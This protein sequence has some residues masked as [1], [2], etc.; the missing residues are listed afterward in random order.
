MQRHSSIKLDLLIGGALTLVGALTRIPYLS[1]IPVFDDEVMQTVYAL[2]IRPGHFMPLVGNDSY[3]G[4]LFS[5]ILAI[6]LRVFGASPGRAAHRRD[7][8]GRT[9]GGADI[10]SGARVGVTLAV[11]STGRIVDGGQSTSHSHQQPLCR[12]DLH[13]PAVQHGLSGCS[14]PGRPAQVGTVVGR[15]QVRCWD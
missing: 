6:C 3:A 13:R 9:D 14:G 10:S 5:Y 4:P 12:R 15:W 11:G 1:L 2:S 7:G 8:H